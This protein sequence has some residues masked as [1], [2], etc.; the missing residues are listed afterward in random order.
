M[1]SADIFGLCLYGDGAT[2]KRMPLINV[3]ASSP[4]LTTA[5]LEI[6]D[7]SNYL[8]K[9]V[10]KS[11][12]FI[13][14]LF[15]PHLQKLDPNKNL[16]DLLYFDGAS[17]VQKAGRILMQ[18]YKRVSCYHGAEHVIG[19]FFSD[20]MKLPEFWLLM[21]GS[22][23]MYKWFGSGT[24]QKVHAV[25]R[26]QS[27]LFNNG[28]FVGLFRATDVRMAGH[29][30]S[31]LRLIRAKAW[32]Q[33]TTYAAPIVEGN[34]LPLALVNLSRDEDYYRIMV[35]VCCSVF[36]A[37]RLLRMVDNQEPAMSHLC[38]CSRRI[39]DSF[40]QSHL[41]GRLDVL[42]CD[43]SLCSVT[44]Q[45]LSKYFSG[46]KIVV[47][48]ANAVARQHEQSMV[49]DNDDSKVESVVSALDVEVESDDEDLDTLTL[50]NPLQM[51]SLST[52]C[53]ICWNKRLEHL[54]HDYAIVGWM[55]SPVEI[56]RQDV[57]K[58]FGQ[59]HIDAVNRLLVKLLLVDRGTTA[60]NTR[61]KNK[62]IDTFWKEFEWWQSKEGPFKGMDHIW[63]SADVLDNGIHWFH[64]KWTYRTTKVLGRLA[65]LV[66]SKILGIGSAERAWGDVKHLKTDKRSH[67]GPDTIKMQ[68]TLHG[69]WCA[70]KSKIRRAAKNSNPTDPVQAWEDED[71]DA[72]GL[73]KFG[74]NV[75]SFEQST[76]VT[77][78]RIFRAWVED[79]ELAAM[80]KYDPTTEA[81]LLAKHKSMFLLDQDNDDE[82]LSIHPHDMGW[83]GDRGVKSWCVRAI[84]EGF[85]LSLAKEDQDSSLWQHWIINTDLHDCIVAYH[86]ANNDPLIRIVTEAEEQAATKAAA[87]DSSDQG[88][89][90]SNHNATAI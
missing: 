71:M 9:G 13:A 49:V 73:D 83:A 57:H 45:N 1:K 20:L 68:A 7:C 5:V 34:E 55:L 22:R 40:S 3:L 61:A 78:K 69:A 18:D 16:V 84:K 26:E 82:V 58:H 15:R 70:E 30:I 28:R 44:W 14:D 41:A 23:A 88:S 25:F 56:V 50:A 8:S 4:Y 48:F 19:L 90:E 31:F 2:V 74:I 47:P 38:C 72:L 52:R 36:S 76:D 11:A 32:V 46:G 42:G 37:L 75:T 86:K 6:V 89:N 12:T 60:A 81:S 51:T 85:D 77:G 54:Q 67:L 66:S 21:V 80:T 43:R 59:E 79:W 62:L 10:S 33:S 24:H 39:K 64:K 35:G 63:G 87:D 53:L 17:N 29:V 65:C 27:K